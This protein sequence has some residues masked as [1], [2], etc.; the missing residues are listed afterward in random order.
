[1]DVSLLRQQILRALDEA[2]KDASARRVTVDQAGKAFD[3]FLENIATPLMRQAAAVL[4]AEHQSFEVQTPGGSVRLAAEYAPQTFIELELDSSGAEPQV[5]GRVS[6]TRGRQGHVIEERPVAAGKAVA[7]VT[8]D[9]V[10]R[11]LIA[12]VSKLVLKS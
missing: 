7:D 12:E 2:R 6:L 4:R 8:E 9:D 10:S 5:I 1:M 11:F 3:A